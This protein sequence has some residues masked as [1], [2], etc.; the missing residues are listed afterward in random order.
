VYKRQEIILIMILSVTILFFWET[1]IVFPIKLFVVILHEI[2]HAAAAI[3][4]GGTVKSI[5]FSM[6]LAGITKS[7]GGN[8]IITASAGYLGSLLAGVLLYLSSKNKKLRIWFTTILSVVLFLASVNLISG[9]LQTF[10]TILI[11]VLFYLL[12]RYIPESINRV[13]LR[14]LG[15]I[16]CLY[17]I[18]DIKQDLLTTTLRETDTQIL[19]Y[20]TGIPALLIGLVWFLVSVLVLF[21]LLRRE[22]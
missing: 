15:I 16:S 13:F 7:A 18:S 17:I 9:G 10:L 5:D 11:A 22:F 14:F 3:L 6:N 4:T 19:E 2:S 20:M 12:P 21:Y 1:G 8:M